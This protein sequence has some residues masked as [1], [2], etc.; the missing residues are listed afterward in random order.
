MFSCV[1]HGVTLLLYKTL[2]LLMSI[3]FSLLNWKKLLILRK[4]IRKPNLRVLDTVIVQFTY[5]WLSSVLKWYGSFFLP[6]IQ[7][8]RMALFCFMFSFM[9]FLEMT[10]KPAHSSE[11]CACWAGFSQVIKWKEQ[12]FHLQKC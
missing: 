1:N 9:I 6:L 10:L 12:L 5:S 8:G 2:I 4:E 3:N 7:A 11:C